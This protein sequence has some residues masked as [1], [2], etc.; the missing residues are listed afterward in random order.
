MIDQKAVANIRDH[1]SFLRSAERKNKVLQELGFPMGQKADYAFIAGCI[2]PVLIPHVFKAL[3]EL[4]DYFG[5]SYTLLPR[6]HCCGYPVAQ[7]AVTAKN[8]EE[9]A[10]AKELSKEFIRENFKQAKALGAKSIVFFCAGCE[11]YY[12]NAEKETDLEVISYYELLD[13]Y[14]KGGRLDLE[15]DYYAGCYLFRRGLTEQALDIEPAKRVLEKINGLKVNY[16][17]NKL[18]CVIEPLVEKLL[19][20][21]T[22]K[23]VITICSGCQRALTSKLKDKPDIQLKMLPEIVLEAIKNK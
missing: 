1:G 8:D 13:R 11:P 3:K 2:H 17:D 20:S 22:T 16:L 12:A 19:A 14:F 9:I 5:I 6:E 15:A 23:T 4:M 18:C 21:I 7:P 10:R